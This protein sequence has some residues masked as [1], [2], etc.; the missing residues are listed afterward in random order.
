MY[1]SV[2]GECLFVSELCFLLY[3]FTGAV[4]SFIICV[5]AC[6]IDI[7]PH[8]SF[9]HMLFVWSSNRVFRLRHSCPPELV[10]APHFLIT[11]VEPKVSGPPHLLNTVVEVK[12][13]GPPPFLNTVVGVKVSGPPHF[14]I[15]MVGVKVSGPPPFINTV[16]GVKSQDHHIY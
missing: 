4:I 1:L 3:F 13:P 6:N 15:A 16:V 10:F 5:V 9:L 7:F 12:V 2:L 11:V 8:L 14:L